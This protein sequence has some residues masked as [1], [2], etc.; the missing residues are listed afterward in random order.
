MKKYLIYLFWVLAT[1]LI[2]YISMRYTGSTSSILAQVEPQ[3]SAI[4]FQKAVRVKEIFVIPGQ[5]V[6][7]GDRL[8]TVE[9]QDLILDVERKTNELN[10]IKSRLN[11]MEVEKGYR[12]STINLDHEQKVAKVMAAMA[13]LDLEIANS[14]Q[15][16]KSLLAMNLLNDST[17]LADEKS[18]VL[19]KRMLQSELDNLRRLHKL[20]V[21]EI[22]EIYSLKKSNTLSEI[23]H[24]K[25]EIEVLMKEERELIQFANRDG[26]IGNVYAE[27]DELVSPYTTI[28]SLYDNHP[29][30]IRALI[31]ENQNTDLKSGDKVAVES[32]NRKY[33]TNGTII[34]FGSRIIEYPNRLKAYQEVP[35][36][37]REIF[38]EIPMSSNFLNGEK[39]F[40]KLNK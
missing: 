31:N 38:I 30:I 33:K 28:I 12:L 8:L 13:S 15:I 9:R 32:T 14:E 24:T 26:T 17:S 25:D 4:S 39:V 35:V 22:S 7:K 21:L 2:I 11:I 1:A 23:Q 29:T 37:G 34:E 20:N 19:K 6:K 40:V 36:Y 5:N 18:L 16:E 27:T 3:K 10:G